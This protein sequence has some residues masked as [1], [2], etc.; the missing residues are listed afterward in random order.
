[1]VDLV[2][3]FFRGLSVSVVSFLVGSLLELRRAMSMAV[4]SSS[5]PPVSSPRP[6]KRFSEALPLVSK[7]HKA[8]ALRSEEGAAAEFHRRRRPTRIAI[9]AADVGSAFPEGNIVDSEEDREFHLEERCYSVA[10]RRGNKRVMEDDY[11]VITN[12]RGDPKQV[13]RRR[14]RR[15]R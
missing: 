2:E 8:T 7:R 13:R 15:R 9:P 1:M 4:G 3:I 5:P 11:G 10:S 6:W 14:R 12:I